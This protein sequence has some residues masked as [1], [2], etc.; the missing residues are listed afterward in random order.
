MTSSTE[1]GSPVGKRIALTFDDGP[2]ADWTPKIAAALR[3]LQAP[4]TFF[5]VGS[6]VVRHPDVVRR[7]APRRLR[8]GESH[9]HA[10][11]RR[12][13]SGPGSCG[14]DRP[15]RQRAGR[16]GGHPPAALQA[17]VLVRPGS[18]DPATGGRARG[19]GQPRLRRRAHRLRR[20]GLAA[21]GCRRDRRLR[22]AS[23]RPRAESCSSTTVAVSARRRFGQS[24][25]SVP[26][27]RARGF[28][29]V[30]VSELAGLSREEAEVPVGRLGTACAASC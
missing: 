24:S 25:E 29:F 12:R 7:S 15:D 1:R 21:A 16:N 30:T 18:H 10:C 23:R 22:V 20:R 6:K 9:V 5:V 11:G 4:A 28:E 14:S 2:D 27:L 19:S 8:T 26:A 17:A 3:R 13:S